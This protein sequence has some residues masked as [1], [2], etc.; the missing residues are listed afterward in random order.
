MVSNATDVVMGGVAGENRYNGKITGSTKD[1]DYSIVAADLRFD[2]NGLNYFGNMGG[3]AGVNYNEISGYEF[4]GYIKGEA[5]DPSR[6][7]SFSVNYDL[8]Q[9]GFRVYGYGG[10]VG[11]NGSDETTLTAEVE[12]CR[13]G[14]AKIEG[15]GDASNGPMSG[16]WQVLMESTL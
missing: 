11:M 13:L 5:N 16:A 10:I 4:N 9:S 3:I 8:E 12:K 14:M 15:T 2:G 1:V 6:S 7:P